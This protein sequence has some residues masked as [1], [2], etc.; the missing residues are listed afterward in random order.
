MP[1]YQ[2]QQCSN[3]VFNNSVV[4]CF[5]ILVDGVSVKNTTPDN[6]PLDAENPEPG[7][8]GVYSDRI[9][10]VQVQDGSDANQAILA[11]VTKFKTEQENPPTP[12]T[13]TEVSI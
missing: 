11:Y 2:T 8:V 4:Y 10:H 12:A 6:P 7:W 5:K 3:H 9:F 1:S 13:I